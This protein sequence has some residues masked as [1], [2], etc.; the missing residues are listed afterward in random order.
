M[1]KNIIKC[2]FFDIGGVLFDD[3]KAEQ[4]RKKYLLEVLN[5]WDREI[6]SANIEKVIPKASG[7]I[8]KLNDNILGE[9]IKN[10]PA[11]SAAS[12]QMMRLWKD[13]VRYHQ[14]SKVR[15]EAKSVLKVLSEKYML[16]IL[17]NQALPTKE[18]LIQAGVEKYFEHFTVS[19]EYDLE[20]PDPRFFKAI[21]RAAGANPKQSVIIDDNIERGLLPA[22]KLGMTTV[23]Y[24]RAERKD[25]PESQIDYTIK[26]LKDLLNI[27]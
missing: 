3:S 20:K 21:F 16:G 22:K 7:I 8:G 26:S 11:F 12:E 6:T 5:L 14:N 2:I 17:A 13:K 10:K 9:F 18:R 1:T 15:P 4:L 24:K 25:I 23:W 19:A 27:F